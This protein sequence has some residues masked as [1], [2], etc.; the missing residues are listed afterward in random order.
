MRT[1]KYV[2]VRTVYLTQK[3]SV[4]TR[5]FL[6]LRFIRFCVYWSAQKLHN[7]KIRIECSGNAT[8]EEAESHKE[9]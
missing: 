8:L 9:T 1:Y 5:T 3:S 2:Q 4:W 7:S 6:Y